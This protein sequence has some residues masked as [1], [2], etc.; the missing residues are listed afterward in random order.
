MH[1]QVATSTQ[2]DWPQWRGPNRDGRLTAFVVPARWPARLARKW[3]VEVGEG[4]ASPLVAG[5][6]AY[7]FARAGEK[8]ITRRLDFAT[9]R[10][11][12]RDAYSAPYTM[13]PAAQGHGKGPKSTP[14][15]VNGSLYTLGISGILSCLD[16]A[17]GKVRWRHDAS[18]RHKQTAP[19][20][21]TAMSP[22]VDRGLLIAHLGGHDDGE[23][24]AF[25]ARSGRVRWRWTED[26]PA[27]ASPI[28]VTL[29]GVR[30]IVT[31]TQKRCI[32]LATDSGKLLWSLPFTTAF[33][34]NSITPV[35]AGDRL[36]F[37]GMRQPTFAVSVRKAGANWAAQKV[38][39]TRD[40]TMY[41]S[42]PVVSGKRLYGL[43]ERRSGQMFCLDVDTG[44]TLWT[45][46][47]RL[48]DNAS[49]WLAGPFVLALTTGAD[50][51][52]YQ[53]NGDALKEAARYQVAD[54]PTWASPAFARDR[55]LAKDAT[56]L[57][58]WA[59][60]AAAQAAR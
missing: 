22:I 16:A 33:D 51:I 10:E 14:V 12:W 54:S 15:Y 41:M 13:N 37:A 4:H 59:V 35:A 29:D 53:K 28:L 21:G 57:A 3:K 23:L 2:I 52:V 45:G 24:T 50:L 31:Q 42:T 44:K 26:G 36:I 5:N 58:L 55:L 47:G 39:E 30:Q 11:I 27:Y 8:E 17:S 19:L 6:S 20:Y 56:T 60:P 1:R 49:I 48:G 9:G 34:Q 25:D 18:A 32:G 43:S 38:W 46:E 40:V 7:V